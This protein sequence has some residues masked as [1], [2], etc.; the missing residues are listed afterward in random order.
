M[1]YELYLNGI[2]NIVES[3]A[4]ECADHRGVTG[5]QPQSLQTAHVH[6]DVWHL[7]EVQDLTQH[8]C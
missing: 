7:K 6:L 5:E 1:A 8:C 4:P 3:K 2:K